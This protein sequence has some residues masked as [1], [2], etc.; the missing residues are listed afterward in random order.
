M[1]KW[2][3]YRRK[4]LYDFRMEKKRGLLDEYRFPGFCPKRDIKGIFGDPKARVIQLQRSQKKRHAVAVARSIGAIT[5]RKCVVSVIFHAG[6]PVSFWKLKSVGF[7][8]GG[9]AR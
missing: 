8:A 2:V 3:L 6:M 1:G 9:A 5:T 7:S 4:N